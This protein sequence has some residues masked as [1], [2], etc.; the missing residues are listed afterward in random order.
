M[1]ENNI[2]TD[3]IH[4]HIRQVGLEGLTTALPQTLSG[5]Q[6]QRVALART[7]SEDT[8]VVI[9]DEPFSAVDAITRHSLQDMAHQLLQDK[10]VFMVTHDPI[11]AVRLAD[12]IYVLN[13]GGDITEINVPKKQQSNIRH[14][15]DAGFAKSHR[16]ILQALD[17]TSKGIL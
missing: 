16:D 7:L 5:G 12:R 6:R 8:P 15:D 17:N 1:R 3:H 9:M 4:N 11:E 13:T 10:T 2:P 14:I